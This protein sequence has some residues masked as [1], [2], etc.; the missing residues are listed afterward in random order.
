[1]PVRDTQPEG[2]YGPLIATLPDELR[3]FDDYRFPNGL[4][5]YMSDLSRFI[6]GDQRVFPIM[7]A[8]GLSVAGWYAA[9]LGSSPALGGSEHVPNR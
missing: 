2:H 6:G 7:N 3:T 5:A 1:M 9:A 4:H 8:A